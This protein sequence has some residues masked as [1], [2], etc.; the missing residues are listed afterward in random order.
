MGRFGAFPAARAETESLC[1]QRSGATAAWVR[2]LQRSEHQLSNRRNPLTVLRISSQDYYSLLLLAAC[3]VP[4]PRVCAYSSLARTF[5]A[6][7][8]YRKSSAAVPGLELPRHG[9]PQSEHSTLGHRT[10]P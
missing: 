7:C 6:S 10:K 2:R 1:G 4:A 9:D 3:P 8:L 5:H